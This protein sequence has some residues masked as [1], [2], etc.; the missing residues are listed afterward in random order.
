MTWIQKGKSRLEHIKNKDVRKQMNV[1][2]LIIEDIKN[3]TRKMT[4]KID[5]W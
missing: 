1:R 5:A 3:I 2:E 4:G